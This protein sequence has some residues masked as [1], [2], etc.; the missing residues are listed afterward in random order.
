MSVTV[1]EEVM[2]QAWMLDFP[3]VTPKEIRRH[4]SWLWRISSSPS[5]LGFRVVGPSPGHGSM[6]SIISPRSTRTASPASSS[7]S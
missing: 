1:W 6:F 5:P 7:G 3:K 2:Q 4:G